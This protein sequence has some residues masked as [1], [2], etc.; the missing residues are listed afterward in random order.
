MRKT[1]A[2]LEDE[3]KLMKQDRDHLLSKI[4]DLEAQLS[5]AREWATRHVQVSDRL[6]NILEF[7]AREGR[8]YGN[9]KNN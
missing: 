9:T 3:L 6:L 1:I 5:V 2:G 7:N 4:K 8:G